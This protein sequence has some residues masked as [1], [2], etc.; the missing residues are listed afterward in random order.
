MSAV[1]PVVVVTG[2]SSGIGAAGAALFAEQ[3]WD[4]H[5]LDRSAPADGARVTHHVVDVTDEATLRAAADAVGQVD[6]L[7]T[8]AGVN[9]TPSD[10]SAHRLDVDAWERTL[11]INLTGTMLAVRAFFPRLNDGG[12]IVTLGSTAGISAMIGQ[13]AYTAS[14]GAVVALTRSWAVDFSRY[15]IRA[16]CV[17]PGPTET[18]ML[19]G[20]VDGLDERHQLVLPQ[21]RP[22]TAR[23][24][25]EVVVFAGSPSASYLSGAV[26]PVDGGAT[27]NTAGMPFPRRRDRHPVG[28]R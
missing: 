5:V 16:N 27:A 21:Q 14:K 7:V 24:I 23:E 25:A 6:C 28:P 22:A 8:A 11:A 2:G 18:A 20:I 19:A 17:C 15:G 9:L 13:D 1:A 3:G 10:S 12:A 4:V 26:I